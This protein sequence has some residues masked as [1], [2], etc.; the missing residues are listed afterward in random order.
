MSA[1]RKTRA[2]ACAFACGSLALAG[3][4]Q[5]DFKNAP[6]PAA[7]IAVTGVIQDRGVTISPGS[8][9]GS[10]PVLITI[11]NQ[12]N[13]AHTVTLKGAS[14]EE[15]V[16]P[17]NPRDTAT[18]QKTLAAGN[19][20]VKAGSERAVAKEIPPG[21]LSVGLKKRDSSGELLLP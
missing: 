18:I 14:V 10:G 15:T 13:D 21:S 19:Y 7:A 5:G 1:L 16:G 20:D 2:G 9:R 12:T 17:I 4:G 6:R 8:V 3:C 11:S